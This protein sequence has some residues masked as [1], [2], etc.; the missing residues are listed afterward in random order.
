MIVV[1]ACLAGEKCRYDG[2]SN[3]C[4]KVVDLV[5]KG[6]AIPVCPEVLGGLSTPRAPAEQKGEKVFTINGVDV[7]KQFVDGANKCLK[8]AQEHNCKTALL[9]ARS[10][11]CGSNKIYDGTFSKRLIVG[12]GVLAGLLKKNGIKVITEE[13]L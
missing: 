9:K 12:D 6:E 1:S 4:Q 13:D 7:T 5:A 8:I 10:P 11:S 2:K 3:Y